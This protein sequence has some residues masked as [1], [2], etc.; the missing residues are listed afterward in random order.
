M[1]CGTD[2]LKTNWRSGRTLVVGEEAEVSNTH[3]AFGEQVQQEAAQE[4]IDR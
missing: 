4:F 2:Q 1:W 3:E